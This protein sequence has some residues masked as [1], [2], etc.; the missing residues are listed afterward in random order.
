M[1][2]Q[3]K[4]K[5]ALVV[6]SLDKHLAKN[7]RLIDVEELTSLCDCFVIAHGNSSTQVK[8][9]ADYVEKELNDNGI[10][11]LR[12]EGFQSSGWVLIDYG[13]VIVHVFQEEMRGFYDLE[14]L[15][16]DGADVDIAEFID[17]EETT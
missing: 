15:W 16:K 2:A 9:L 12:V 6:K 8:A 4:E 3:A 1:T 13:D 7:I 11:P 10:A 17:N 5:A 14:H